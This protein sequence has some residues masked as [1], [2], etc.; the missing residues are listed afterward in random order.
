MGVQIIVQTGTQKATTSDVL[1][2]IYTQDS[3]KKIR[4][5]IM[6]HI[7][8]LMPVL[9]LGV[10]WVLPLP[11]AIPVYLVIL[12]GSLFVYYAM[13]HAM[14]CPVQT[15]VEGM[16]GDVGDALESLNPRGKVLMHG[17]IWK[18]ESSD[19][20]KKGDQV[21]VVGANGLMLQVRRV[22][23]VRDRPPTKN[24]IR[25]HFEPLH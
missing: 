22:A 10:F 20:T 13:I 18:A 2:R 16:V 3:L 25:G 15:G 6:C 14:H 5:L 19:R 23:P 1:P 24:G 7:V 4:R 12:A 21:E 9:G 8:L 17:E 11:I